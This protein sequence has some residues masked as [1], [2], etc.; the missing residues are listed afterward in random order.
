LAADLELVVPEAGTYDV[1]VSD[2]L[3]MGRVDA[4][5]VVKDIMRRWKPR[6]I[7]LTGIAG[8]FGRAGVN[9]GDVRI[10]DTSTS[11]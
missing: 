8:G 2:L 9:L 7:I 3:L 4:A 6:F 10:A 5:I 11:E 1:I